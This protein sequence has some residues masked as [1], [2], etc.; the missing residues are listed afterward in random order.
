MRVT[1]DLGDWS[2]LQPRY[3]LFF[4]CIVMTAVVA[5]TAGFL[6]AI[7]IPGTIVLG[8]NAGI[9]L[10]WVFTRRRPWWRGEPTDEP[11]LVDRKFGRRLATVLAIDGLVAVLLLTG[12]LTR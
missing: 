9:A 1:T 7:S 3:R 6:N 2:T 10:Q 4:A 11:D 5:A 12:V 8:L